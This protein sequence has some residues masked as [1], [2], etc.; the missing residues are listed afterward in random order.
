[1]LH[2]LKKRIRH[3]WHDLYYNVVSDNGVKFAMTC[4]DVTEKIDLNDQSKT[5]LEKFRVKLHVS[6]CQACHNYYSFS[7]TLKTAFKKLMT[8]SKP[9][10]TD[11][12]KLNRELL[13]KYSK[14]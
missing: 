4:K 6:L 10:K 7:Q 3:Y 14:N 12:E 1:M 9:T 13:Q 5:Q 11:L 8:S 2:D